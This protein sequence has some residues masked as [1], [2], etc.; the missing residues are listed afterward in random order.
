MHDEPI[1]FYMDDLIILSDQVNEIQKHYQEI[2]NIT[3]D[4]CMM[5]QLLLIS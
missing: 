1:R 4:A 2:D 5:S 3:V